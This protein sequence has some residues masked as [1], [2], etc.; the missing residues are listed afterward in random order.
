LFLENLLQA[1]KSELLSILPKKVSL[2]QVLKLL[3]ERSGAWI[4]TDQMVRYWT[5][6]LGSLVAIGVSWGRSLK[7]SVRW[8]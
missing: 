8:G 7:D 2:D 3:F 1:F 4:E 6:P 5:T